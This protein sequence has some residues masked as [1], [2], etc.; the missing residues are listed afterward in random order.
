MNGAANG[1]A[2]TPIPA[3]PAEARPPRT[4]HDGRTYGARLRGAARIWLPTLS[5]MLAT[6]VSYIDRNTLAVLAPSILRD[7]RLTAAEYGLV[8]SAFAI[9]YVAGNLVWGRWLDRS[10]IFW[11]MAAAVALWSAASVAHA[12]ASGFL[13]FVAARALLGFAEGATIPGAVRPVVQTLPPAGRSRGLAVAYSG[14]SLGAIATPIVVLLLVSTE[15]EGWRIPFRVIGALGIFWV[16]GWLSTIR[17]AASRTV[18]PS[19]SATRRIAASAAIKSILSAPPSSA[20]RS[21]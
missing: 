19:G 7:T 15:L 8:V 3:S 6:L 16:V 13:G 21:R 1:Q 20:S 17:A 11:V 2:D 9:T 10:G 5:M 18:S 12:F 4:D 14:A